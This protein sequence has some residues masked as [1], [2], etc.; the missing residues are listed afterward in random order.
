MIYM[1]IQLIRDFKNMR[2]Y[3]NMTITKILQL[4][5]QAQLISY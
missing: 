1:Q 5:Q 3:I 4:S 2:Q